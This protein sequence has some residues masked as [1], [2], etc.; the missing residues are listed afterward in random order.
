MKKSLKKLKGF[1]LIELLIVIAI[2]AVLGALVFV[3]LNPL[4]RFQDSRNAKR[5]TDVNSILSA[6]K[7]NQIDNDGS[8][9]GDIDDLTAGLYYQIGNGES[10]NNTCSNPTVVLQS[11]C[12]DLEGL[13]DGGYLP[14]IPVDPNDSGA[15]EEATRYFLIKNSNGSITVGSCSEEA[16]TGG[17]APYIQVSR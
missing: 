6:I 2:I 4:G 15:D 12:V 3:A 7:L 5:W 17:T 16:G 11:D 1:T 14:E 13:I 8:Y 9:F 10:C